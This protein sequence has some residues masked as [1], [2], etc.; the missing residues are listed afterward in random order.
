MIWQESERARESGL[1]LAHVVLSSNF[2]HQFVSFFQSERR[3]I[4]W[5][6]K[7]DYGKIHP[8][9]FSL[10]IVIRAYQRRCNARA[11]KSI[12]LIFDFFV[13]RVDFLAVNINKVE[14]RGEITIYLCNRASR[15]DD[16]CKKGELINPKLINTSP[17]P[18]LSTGFITAKQQRSEMGGSWQNKY[19]AGESF[20]LISSNKS[21]RPHKMTSWGRLCLIQLEVYLRVTDE[22]RRNCSCVVRNS[23]RNVRESKG[24]AKLVSSHMKKVGSRLP[25]ACHLIKIKHQLHIIGHRFFVLIIQNARYLPVLVNII[26]IGHQYF[27]LLLQNASS[28]PVL[29]VIK[30]DSASKYWKI[31]MGKNL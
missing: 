26:C 18:I 29:V 30:M 19:L 9:F 17:A 13:N 14:K 2:F 10:L 15:E 25:R 1:D 27:V 22:E 5:G 31:R 12:T 8:R 21:F 28:H 7:W 11:Y 23:P 16:S 3:H 20:S 4:R 6:R 24:M